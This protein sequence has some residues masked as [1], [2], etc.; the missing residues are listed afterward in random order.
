M[1]EPTELVHEYIVEDLNVEWEVS[2]DV[3][4]RPKFINMD[5]TFDPD[6]A[7]RYYD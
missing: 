5:G 4:E 7:E 3:C 1:K 2:A 6:I